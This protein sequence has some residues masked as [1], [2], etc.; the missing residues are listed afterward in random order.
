MK[1]VQCNMK[2]FSKFYYLLKNLSRKHS[3]CKI[4]NLRNNKLKKILD[5]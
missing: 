3:A 2:N 5:I 1:K 4:E